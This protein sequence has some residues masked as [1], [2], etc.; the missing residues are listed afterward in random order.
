[1]RASSI[2]ET[3]DFLFAEYE[4]LSGYMTQY[5]INITP[6]PGT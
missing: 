4:A 1:M 5:L 3:L 6:K 2:R